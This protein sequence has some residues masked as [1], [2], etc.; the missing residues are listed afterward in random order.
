MDD[1]HM[2]GN[3]ELQNGILEDLH[4]ILEW[5]NPNSK[6]KLNF[7]LH[8]WLDASRVFS[9]YFEVKVFFLELEF[10][11]ILIMCVK[12]THIIIMILCKILI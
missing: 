4:W 8:K 5:G 9:E 10:Q 11:E 2:L 6:T 3:K 12:I 1:H 7:L